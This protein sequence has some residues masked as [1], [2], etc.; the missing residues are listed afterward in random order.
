MKVASGFIP[1][2]DIPSLRQEI[3][4]ELISNSLV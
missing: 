4:Q 2:A 3:A 1:Q